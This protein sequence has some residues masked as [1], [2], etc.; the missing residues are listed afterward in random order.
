MEYIEHEFD[1]TLLDAGAVYQ[2]A[3]RIA[4]NHQDRAASIQNESF[5][6]QINK[7]IVALKEEVP[8]E[9]AYFKLESQLV[10]AFTIEQMDKLVKLNDWFNTDEEFIGAYFQKTF[11]EEL[12]LE[13]Q[14][15]WSTEEKIENL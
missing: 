13:N 1:F 12:S 5:F 6:A 3:K 8:E 4:L 10:K 2:F 7:H 9:F 11:S 14:E 15:M